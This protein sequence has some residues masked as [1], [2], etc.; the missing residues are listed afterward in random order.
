[1]YNCGVE[2]VE[3]LEILEFSNEIIHFI[4]YFHLKSFKCTMFIIQIEYFNI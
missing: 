1:M 2:A 3:A 4:N